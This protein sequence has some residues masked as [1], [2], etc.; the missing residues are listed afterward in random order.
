MTQF[1]CVKFYQ[2]SQTQPNLGQRCDVLQ[3][4]S[5]KVKIE[6]VCTRA[7]SI[8]PQPETKGLNKSSFQPGSRATFLLKTKRKRKEKEVFPT[9]KALTE[10]KKAPCHPGSRLVPAEK[11]LPWCAREVPTGSRIL[12][13][14][15]VQ[16]DD[17]I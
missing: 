1:L 13:T 11:S 3:V 8:L 9:V 17:A 15:R 6:R 10:F 5:P 7:S 4:G 12:G 14:P 16:E 2:S